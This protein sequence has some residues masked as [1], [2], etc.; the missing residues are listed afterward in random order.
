MLDNIKHIQASWF[1]EGKKTGQIA[2]RFGAVDF[3]GTLFDENVM[4]AAGF[5]NRTTKDEVEDMIKE[6]GYS[7]V[8]RLTD[9][10]LVYSH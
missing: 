3:G 10:S 7:P 6:S 9:Y 5:Y 2:L 1:S 8:E 4:L